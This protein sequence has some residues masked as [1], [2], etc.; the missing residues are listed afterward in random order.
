MRSRDGP[1]REQLPHQL[2]QHLDPPLESLELV[3]LL[4][5]HGGGGAAAADRIRRP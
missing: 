2:L 3:G 4:F 1:G 5:A